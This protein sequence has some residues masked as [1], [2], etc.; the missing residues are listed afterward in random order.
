MRQALAALMV[1]AA[2]AIMASVALAMGT[3]HLIVMNVYGA[4]MNPKIHQGDLVL[5]WSTGHYKVGDA[6]AYRARWADPKRPQTV[7]HRIVRKQADGLTLRGDNNPS[8][9]PALINPSDVMGKLITVVPGGGSMLGRLRS[10]VWIIALALASLAILW[11][12]R[13]QLNEAAEGDIDEFDDYDDLHD[14]DAW[15]ARDNA[16]QMADIHRAQVA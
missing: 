13:E 8:E 15:S 16:G 12:Q 9:D 10:M 1:W 6:V 4:S 3:H 14:P 11:P 5:T 7:L 2:F